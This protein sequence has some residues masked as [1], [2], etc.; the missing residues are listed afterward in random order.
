LNEQVVRELAAKGWFQALGPALD[1][2]LKRLEG[3]R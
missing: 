3:R 1:G 2:I